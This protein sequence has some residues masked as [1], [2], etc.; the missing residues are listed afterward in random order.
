MPA[1]R[2]SG[3]SRATKWRGRHWD[4]TLDVINA[5]VLGA[6]WAHSLTR[7]SSIRRR[8]FEKHPSGTDHGS[9]G[10]AVEGQKA[11]L[12]APVTQQIIT[13]V[14]SSSLVK[15]SSTPP[16]ESLQVRNFSMIQVASP[17]GESLSP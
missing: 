9:W 14:S 10:R 13:F 11:A 7:N 15:R 1:A 17:T 16:L 8:D 6:G 2:A 5:F 4:L 12:I 3:S